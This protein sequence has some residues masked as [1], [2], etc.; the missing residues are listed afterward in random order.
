MCD[1]GIVEGILLGLDN[2][3][4]QTENIDYVLYKMLQFQRRLN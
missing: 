3:L 4:R 1:T 2:R